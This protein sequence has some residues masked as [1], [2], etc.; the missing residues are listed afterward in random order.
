MAKAK[1]GDNEKDF[2][3]TFTQKFGA[4]S[5]SGKRVFGFKFPGHKKVTT[6]V[7]ETILLPDGRQILVEID[8][9]NMA[10]LLAGQ[11][12]LLNGLCNEDRKKTLFLVVHYYVDKKN[13]N[14]P[15]AANRT[16]KNLHAIQN[17]APG[18]NWL[19]YHA[20]NIVDMREAIAASRDIA[21]FVAR[22][23]PESAPPAEQAPQASLTVSA[24]PAAAA[25]S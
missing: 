1:A 18:T 14:K 12:A 21:D 6:S 17:F 25:V 23:W 8:S 22:V 24:L 16:T 15:Y 3:R 10:K 11:Y 19:P 5:L 7:D 20:M 4:E 2:H 13:N 9:G